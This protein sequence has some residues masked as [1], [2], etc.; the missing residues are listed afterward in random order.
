MMI[1]FSKMHGL[2]N[3]FVVVDERVERHG[4]TPA[5]IAALA[6]RHR[7]IGCD[8]FVV[9]RPACQAGADVF[10]RFFNADGSESGACGNA[11]RCV[12]DLLWRGEGRRRSV[13]QTRA[14]L[15]PAS[16]DGETG[17]VTVDMGPPALAWRD[18]PLAE[19]ADTLHLPLAGDPAAASMGNPHV[20][21]F[22]AD[23]LDLD[24]VV[25]G[26]LLEHDP[27]FPERANIGFA[28]VLSRAAMRLRV[29][30]RGS[31]LTLA[32]GSGACAAA[33]NAVR[34]GLVE[35]TC[36]V[37]MDGGALSITWR[38][39]DGHVLMTGPA[40]TSFVGSFDPEIYPS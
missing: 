10:V 28:Q 14:G 34:R 4:L 7:G 5:R 26:P 23:L 11:S 15:L 12:A 24:P 13:L 29:W 8:Q 19:P 16:V 31:G 33:V 17:L 9:L 38:D 1:P 22:L 32:C 3:D 40:T 30:E 27:L 20:T 6:D 21:F 37:E 39:G 35:R 25:A 18:V 2:G 36:R